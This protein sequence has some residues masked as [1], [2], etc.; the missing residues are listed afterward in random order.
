MD[1]QQEARAET[2]PKSIEHGAV[3]LEKHVVKV[4]SNNYLAPD[5][6]NRGAIKGDDSDGRVNWTPKR[7]LATLFLSGLYVGQFWI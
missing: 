5:I 2:R 1:Q 6:E 4:G 3:E 7:V